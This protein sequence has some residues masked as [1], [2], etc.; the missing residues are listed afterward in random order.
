[1]TEQLDV[2]RGSLATKFMVLTGALI[3]L[4]ATLIAGFVVALE[5]DHQHTNLVNNA[6]SLAT[7]MARNSEYALYTQNDEALAQVIKDTEERPEIAYVALLSADKKTLG[8]KTA[9]ADLPVATRQYPALN[10]TS[11]H[12]IVDYDAATGTG[13]FHLVDI[14]VPVL[15]PA[16]DQN[17]ALVP[18]GVARE[19]VIGYLQ[20][21]LNKERYLKRFRDF[22]ISTG[23]ITLALVLLGLLLTVLMTRK[24]TSPLKHLNQAIGAFATGA[25]HQKVAVEGN[26]EVAELASTFNEMSERLLEFHDSLTRKNVSLEE[27]NRRLIEEM[28]RRRHMQEDLTKA[29]KLEALGI[30]AGGIAHDFNNLLTAIMGNLSIASLSVRPGHELYEVIHNAEN[31]SHRARDLTSRL[32]T[33]AKGGMP[34]KEPGSIENLLRE[35]ASFAAQGSKVK[36]EFQFQNDLWGGEYDAGQISQV[37]NNLV[38]NAIQSMPAGGVITIRASNETVPTDNAIFLKGGKFVKIAIT[39]QGPGIPAE[40]QSK[41]FDPY[42]TTKAHGSGLGLSS[43]YSIVKQHN[44][45]IHVHS[46]AG[47]G[48]TILFYLPASPERTTASR[49]LT[50]SGIM[51]GEGKILVMDDEAM[52]RDVAS[53]MLS[54]LGYEVVCAADGAEAV[55]L[56]QEAMASP[57]PFAAVIMDLTIPGGM[58]GA[59]AIQRLLAIDPGVKGIVSSGYSNDP[60]MAEHE[61]HGFRGVVPKPFMVQNL[62]LALHKV[63]LGVTDAPATRPD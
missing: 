32:L 26:D 15:T 5:A 16:T 44:G 42:F 36:C 47:E 51:T 40:I 52:V 17:L 18:G 13:A 22:L 35:T 62:S 28:T 43:C 49:M 9:S 10:G 60:I 7:A 27:A 53:R 3:L 50:D 21:G 59:E 33:F 20:L 25:Y 58:G 30:L 11:E 4:T 56:Y 29:K 34:I 54:R 57:P 55:R 8:V 48:A 24:I 39:D 2:K 23:S 1:M 41:V 31:A 37:V 6:V 61:K 46:P 14:I 38:L 63:L 12:F 19:Q 45:S